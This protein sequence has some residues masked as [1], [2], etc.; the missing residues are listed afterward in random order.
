MLDRVQIPRLLVAGAEGGSGKTSVAL[1]LV[2][3]L[4]A[5]GRTVQTFKVGPDFVDCSYLAHASGRPCRNLD[6][7]ILG[8]DALRR[9]LIQGSMGAD[10]VVIEGV[11]GLFDSR[12]GPDPWHG[13]AAGRDFPG[14]TADVAHLV[15]APVVLV[16]DVATMS[17]T[18]AAIALGVRK[19]D[20]RLDIAGVILD[21]VVSPERRRV[22]EDAVWERAKLPVL[23]ALPNLEEAAIPELHSGLLPLP[24]NPRVDEAMAALGLAVTRDCDLDLVERL[25]ARAEPMPPPVRRRRPV[26][27]PLRVGVAFDDAFSCYYAENLELLEDAGAEIVTFSPLEDR[28]LPA[29]LGALYLGGGLGEVHLPRLAANH[30]FL[31]GLR[32]AHAL[33]MPIYA[34]SGGLICCARTVRLGSGSVLPL[35]GLLRL[36]VAVDGRPPPRGYREL[37]LET[38]CLLG[39]RGLKLR[40]HEVRAAHPLSPVGDVSPAYAM[41]DCDGEPLGCEGWADGDLLCSFVHLHFAQSPEVVDHLLERAR[42]RLEERRALSA[43]A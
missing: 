39:P 3:A 14:S 43:W 33:G 10:C 26:T 5:R 37:R 19:L 29:D 34:E 32:R 7:W 28:G 22:V 25:M 40:G 1:G 2:A 27:A 30:A 42:R 13:T 17:E 15:G 36:D 9:S 6:S 38:D 23:G 16:L 8:A 41:H 12:G 21:R 35:A 31:D 11:G 24:Q 4:R 20:P 18:A